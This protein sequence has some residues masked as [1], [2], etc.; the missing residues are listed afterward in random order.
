[1]KGLI[2]LVLVLFSLALACPRPVWAADKK[3]E[4]KQNPPITSQEAKKQ[5]AVDK[6]REALFASINNLRGQ[7][8]RVAVLQQLLSEE[9]AKL[10]SV[11]NDFCKQYKLDTEKFRQGL[12]RYDP[13]TNKFVE[14]KPQPQQKAR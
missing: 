14:V 4:V 5:G 9:V 3:S 11:Q 2:S 1:M 10:R 7:E 8:L 12:Y 6:Q 13:N